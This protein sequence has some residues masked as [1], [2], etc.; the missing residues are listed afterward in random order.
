MRAAIDVGG[1][2]LRAMRGCGDEVPRDG[3]GMVEERVSSAEWF[4]YVER[5]WY[6]RRLICWDT[7]NV[8]VDMAELVAP[9]GWVS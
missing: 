6:R 1:H 9:M 7:E 8:N 3:A 5:F 2:R 4:A